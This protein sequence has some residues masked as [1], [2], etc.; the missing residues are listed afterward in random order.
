MASHRWPVIVAPQFD[1][2]LSSWLH[3]LAFANGVAPRAFARVLGLAPGMW[4][5][6]LDLRLPGNTASQLCTNT[7]VSLDHLSGMT[8][9]HALPKRI[10][11]PLRS[12]GRR[13]RSTWLQFCSRCLAEDPHP[14]FRRRWRLASRVACSRHGC[15][16][17]DRC[18]FCR[19]RIAVFDQGKLVPQH[20]CVRCWYDLRRA[21]IVAISPGAK[22]FDGCIDD[23]FRSEAL[24]SSPPGRALVRR[25]QSIPRLA[26]S[27]PESVLTNL[28]TAARTR[29]VERLTRHL[30]DWLMNEED[31]DDGVRQSLIPAADS[32]SSLVELLVAAL[33]PKR[34][35]PSTA[36]NGRRPTLDP[37]K[38]FKAHIET[39][40]MRSL[41][42]T[43]IGQ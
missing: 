6:S 35:R 40:D 30:S 22:W 4:S 34:G 27:F 39:L 21:S 10:L 23:I 19:S 24:S 31:V 41:S 14:Y 37:A 36:M 43:G 2:L 18:P 7:G 20:Y 25:L 28:S 9:S 38:L 33:A 8:L 11:L 32:H 29:C 17:R 3:R 13:D 42:S 26:G 15:R 1:E 12:S 16:L 5:A